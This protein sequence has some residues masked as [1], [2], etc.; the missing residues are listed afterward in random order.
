MT[1]RMGVVVAGG[2]GTRLERGTPK[3]L[4]AVAGMSLLE[5]SVRLLRAVCDSVVVVAPLGMELPIVDARRVDDVPGA[6][7]PLAGV[8]AAL[9]AESFTQALVVAV[10]FPLLRP[11]FLEELASRLA[12]QAAVLPAPHGVPQPLV[13]A[14]SPRAGDALRNALDSGE[15]SI[16]V[17]AARL[18]PRLMS[19]DEIETIE[20]GFE[21][22]LNLNT[23]ADLARA[24]ALLEMRLRAGDAA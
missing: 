3:A 20:G 2:P 23:P 5:R 13:A 9:T 21:N 18:G 8:V 1:G 11:A 7:G 12:G 14:Y 17:A 15:R 4:V 6:A 24:E 22:L 16:T 19:D 10:D